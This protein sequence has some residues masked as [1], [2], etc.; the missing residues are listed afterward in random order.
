MKGKNQDI[1]EDLKNPERTNYKRIQ[2]CQKCQPTQ[3]PQKLINVNY[4]IFDTW[5]YFSLKGAR[6][7]Y[8]LINIVKM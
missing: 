4:C 5:T 8:L 1:T 3:P 6:Q 7:S 2:Q